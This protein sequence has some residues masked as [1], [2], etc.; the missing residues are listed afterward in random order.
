M[1]TPPEHVQAPGLTWVPSLSASPIRV[2]A[3][4]PAGQSTKPRKAFLH[5]TGVDALHSTATVRGGG[6][7]EYDVDLKVAFVEPGWI[8]V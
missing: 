3:T 7:V 6:I 2:G 8:D 4:P 1:T 5:I